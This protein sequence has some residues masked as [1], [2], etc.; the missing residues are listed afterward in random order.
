[1]IAWLKINIHASALQSSSTLTVF[2]KSVFKSSKAKNDEVES[3]FHSGTHTDFQRRINKGHLNNFFLLISQPQFSIFQYF[4]IS[5]LFYQSHAQQPQSWR[6]F[7]M[8][9][10]KFS[11]LSNLMTV[12]SFQAF[13]S[14][15]FY[16]SLQIYRFN[17]F[18]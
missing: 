3:A 7:S 9:F 12:N 14:P 11:I 17:Q 16:N 5:I 10:E 2:R 15:R 4:I 1:M 18:S 13:Y 6:W 8:D